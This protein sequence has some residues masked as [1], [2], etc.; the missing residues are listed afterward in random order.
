MK[1]SEIAQ[2][3]KREWARDEKRVWDI[4]AKIRTQYPKLYGVYMP[5]DNDW[6][7]SGLF[8]PI[9]AA[10]REGITDEEWFAATVKGL[11]RP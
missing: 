5:H 7:V 4:I 8:G 10:W 2:H 1:H 9:K 3:D 11:E 6:D